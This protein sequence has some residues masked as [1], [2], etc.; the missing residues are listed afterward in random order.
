SRLPRV[1]APLTK[2]TGARIVAYL[3]SPQTAPVSREGVLE[4]AD[5]KLDEFKCRL[6]PTLEPALICTFEASQSNEVQAALRHPVKIDGT[7]T[8]TDASGRIDSIRIERITPLDSLDLDAGSFFAH[9]TF[10]ALVRQQAIRPLKSTTQ[11]S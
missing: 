3:Q 1:V 10:D 2:A 9:P 8:M 5:F 7:A 6:R 4:M 11:L